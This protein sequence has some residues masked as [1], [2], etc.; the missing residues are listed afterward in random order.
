MEDFI[1]RLV[2]RSLDMGGT[3][4]GEHGIGQAKMKYMREEHDAGALDL[5]ARIKTAFDPRDLMNPGKLIPR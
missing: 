5:M 2:R 4:S 3:C 1:A